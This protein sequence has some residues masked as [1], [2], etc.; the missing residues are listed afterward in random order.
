MQDSKLQ[1]SQIKLIF[2]GAQNPYTIKYVDDIIIERHTKA[3]KL[4][5][6]INLKIKLK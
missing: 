5:Y 4:Q 3:L 6:Y 2:S 1:V